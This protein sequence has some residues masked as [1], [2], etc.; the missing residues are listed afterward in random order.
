[1]KA[2]TEHLGGPVCWSSDSVGDFPNTWRYHWHRFGFG[3][4]H[5][6]AYWELQGGS[7]WAHGSTYPG[8]GRCQS[9]F[10]SAIRVAVIPGSAS[11]SLSQLSPRRQNCWTLCRRA[12]FDFGGNAW[13]GAAFR[14]PQVLLEPRSIVHTPGHIHQTIRNNCTGRTCSTCTSR[15]YQ[16]IASTKLVSPHSTYFNQGIQISTTAKLHHNVACLV[17]HFVKEVFVKSY[18]RGTVL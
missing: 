8:A 10:L 5:N 6:K 13:S 16:V 7:T 4:I 1:M 9:R 11:A 2:G 3:G 12:I 17:L 18:S 15:T 14:Q